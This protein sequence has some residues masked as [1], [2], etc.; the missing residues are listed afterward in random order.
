MTDLTTKAKRAKLAPNHKPYWQQIR[1]GLHLG[2]RKSPDSSAETWQVR[3]RING[4]YVFAAL[5]A[6]DYPAALRLALAQSDQWNEKGV[7][8]KAT[9]GPLS[10][11]LSECVDY[12]IQNDPKRLD[13][14]E[15]RHRRERTL[16]S[17]ALRFFGELAE[18]KLGQVT[19]NDIKRRQDGLA[20]EIAAKSVNRNYAAARSAVTFVCKRHKLN[21]NPFDGVERLPQDD[22][23]QVVKFTIPE[24]V[25]VVTGAPEPLQPI[26]RGLLYTGARPIAMRTLRAR[27]V[28]LRYGR[29]NIVSLK[30]RKLK[31]GYVSLS[32]EA[33]AF[34]QEQIKDKAASDYVFTSENGKQWTTNNLRV[35]FNRYRDEAMLADGWDLYSFRHSRINAAVLSGMPTMQAAKEFLTSA[36][37]IEKNYSGRDDDLARRFVPS[38]EGA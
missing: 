38:L 6:D 10:W 17:N 20:N 18:K 37:F 27:D 19:D 30:G 13:D 16:R 12:Y 33:L 8:Q 14:E 3:E 23:A 9:K 31:S 34:F 7:E 5:R 2:F 26:L 25:A 32:D 24:A 21:Q 4:R 11:T 1:K 29:L 36:E 28:D 22:S 35:R 15:R